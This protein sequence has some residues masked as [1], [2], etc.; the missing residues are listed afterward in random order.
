M[1]Y[2]EEEGFF[3]VTH[4]TREDIATALKDRRLHG[5]IKKLTDDQMREIAKRMGEYFCESGHYWDFLRSFV[6]DMLKGD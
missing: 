3:A 5:K 2:T 6:P 1:G 4:V